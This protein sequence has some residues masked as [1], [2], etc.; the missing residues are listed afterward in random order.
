[1]SARPAYIHVYHFMDDSFFEQIYY[2]WVA[3]ALKPEKIQPKMMH[4]KKH[5][6]RNKAEQKEYPIS[7]A[8]ELEIHIFF[9]CRFLFTFSGLCLAGVSY[10]F[11]IQKTH[12]IQ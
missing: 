10:R 6:H 4:G 2:F 3:Y 7:F 5:T 1:M 11:E 9:F 8:T 12:K